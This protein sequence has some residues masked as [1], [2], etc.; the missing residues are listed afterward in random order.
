MVPLP[1]QAGD[2]ARGSQTPKGPRT[3]TQG[4]PAC[5]RGCGRRRC[6]KLRRHC[7]RRRV[8]VVGVVV[9]AYVL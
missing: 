2:E 1:S 6:L 3:G 5:C 4:E 9:V 8:G 7:R